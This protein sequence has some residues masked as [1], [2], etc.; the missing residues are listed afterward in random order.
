MCLSALAAVGLAD[1]VELGV[2][3]GSEG[4]HLSCLCALFEGLRE[5]TA[6][7]RKLSEVA[8]AL[9]EL[10]K[11]RLSNGDVITACYPVAAL[12]L[13]EILGL[14]LSETG[15]ECV[16]SRDSAGEESNQ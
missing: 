10:A 15:L 16:S 2:G 3:D 6:Q 7:A 14:F 9:G 1:L 13:S 11:R 12:D 5:A 4:A 8:W